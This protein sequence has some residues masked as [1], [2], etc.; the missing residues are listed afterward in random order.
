V[1]ETSPLPFAALMGLGFLI[2]IAGHLYKSPVMV[3]VGIAVIFLAT[4]LIPLGVYL[5]D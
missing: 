2:G 3:G 1:I 4:L 5:H